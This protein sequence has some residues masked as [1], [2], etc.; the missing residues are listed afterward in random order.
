MN[1][2]QAIVVRT[3][4][5]MSAGKLAAQACHAALGAY[6]KADKQVTTAWKSE[7]G[8]KVVLKAASEAELLEIFETAKSLGL[9]AKLITD[10]GLTEIAPGTKTAVGIGPAKEESVDKVTSELPSL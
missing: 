7:G 2:K 10:A 3:D 5:G 8:K 9:P 6:L 4:L 1:Y